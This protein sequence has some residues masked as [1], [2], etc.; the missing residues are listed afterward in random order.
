[1]RGIDARLSY[2]A[3]GLGVGLEAAADARVRHEDVIFVPLRGEPIVGTIQLARGLR[4]S[5]PAALHVADAIRAT[6]GELG[7]H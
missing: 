1:V 7:R 4:P 3:A 6:A 5:S 2:V